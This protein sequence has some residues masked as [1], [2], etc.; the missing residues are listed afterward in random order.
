[1]GGTVGVEGVGQGSR[2]WFTARMGLGDAP[3]RLTP[4]DLRGRRVLVVDDNDCARR[5]TP[6]SPR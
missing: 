5:W 2:F 3:R 1:M 6:A 4:A